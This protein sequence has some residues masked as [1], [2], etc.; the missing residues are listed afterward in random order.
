MVELADLVLVV[1]DG[2][3]KGTIDTINYAKKLNKP[4]N[5]IM[6]ANADK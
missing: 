6:Y 4:V 2:K 3:S 1:W 5:I